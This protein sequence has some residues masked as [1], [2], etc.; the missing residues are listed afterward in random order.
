MKDKASNQTNEK[1][2]KIFP[3]LTTKRLVQLSMLIALNVVFSRFFSVMLTDS[4]KLSTTF[5]IMAITGAIFGP[6]W[7][8]IAG[9]IAD[10]IGIMLFPQGSGFFIGFTLSA[11]VDCFIYGYFFSKRPFKTYYVFVTVAIST[12]LVSYLMNTYWLCLMTGNNFAQLVIPRV[13]T[14]LVIV[15]VKIIILIPLMKLYEK[16]LA[17][18]VN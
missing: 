16:Q 3:K 15:P 17:R 5:I 8:G 9:V 2:R 12:I 18:F 4:I 7:A 13:M 14:S 6:I 1:F 11:F 10:L